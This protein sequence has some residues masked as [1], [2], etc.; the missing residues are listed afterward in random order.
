MCFYR[1]D[2]SEVNKIAVGMCLRYIKRKLFVVVE[3]PLEIK[4]SKTGLGQ[5]GGG[6]KAM[7]PWII[8]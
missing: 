7:F 3:L 4:G 6:F 1:Y 5:G 2:V 8:F